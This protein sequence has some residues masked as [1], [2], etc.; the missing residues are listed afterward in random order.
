MVTRVENEASG[1]SYSCVFL[2][3]ELAALGLESV[4][5]SL[6]GGQRSHRPPRAPLSGCGTVVG[7]I[8]VRRR[9]GSTT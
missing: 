1:P 3:R 7:A 6:K 9:D 4:L 8:N 5:A 2:S